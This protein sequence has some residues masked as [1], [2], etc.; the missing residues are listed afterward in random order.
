MFDLQT[1]DKLIQMSSIMSKS[2]LVPNG[3]RGKP[4]DVF[5]ILQMG[6]ELG[7]K[8]VQSLNMIHVIQGKPSLSAQS[9]IALIRMKFPDALIKINIDEKN[10]VA[11]CEM[12]RHQEDSNTFIATW[13]MKKAQEMNL[14]GREQYK[15]QAANMLKWRS[16]SEA[17]RVV[18]PDV[19]QGLYTEDEVDDFS[20]NKK[21]MVVLDKDENSKNKLQLIDEIKTNSKLLAGELDDN[22]KEMFKESVIKIKEWK[23]LL[24]KTS[25]E[26]NDINEDL[27]NLKNKKGINNA[28]TNSDEN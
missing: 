7:L 21:T 26:L 2:G 19:I 1:T 27:I 20:D 4:N 23:D 13:D 8:P 25:Q 11:K 28:I 10:L 24:T 18:F 9:M 17:A 5:L 14:V 6:H 15:K 3:L 16:V 22:E 12:G